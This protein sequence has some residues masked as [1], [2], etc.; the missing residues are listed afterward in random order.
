MVFSSVEF[1]FMLFPG[2]LALYFLLSRLPD[3]LKSVRDPALN[4][5]L[6]CASLLF[7][8]WA[9]WIIPTSIMLNKRSWTQKSTYYMIP[10]IK[11]KNKQN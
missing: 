3:K 11:V 9:P 2:T 6:V 10:F 7:Y 1:L 4:V 8:A 5:L